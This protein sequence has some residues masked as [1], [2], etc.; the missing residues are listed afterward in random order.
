MQIL[1]IAPTRWLS[2]ANAVNRILQQ[3][4]DL[5]THFQLKRTADKCYTAELLYNMYADIRN[6]L[7]FVFLKPILDDTLSVNKAFQTNNND[8]VKLLNDLIILIQGLA[9]R[10][11]ISGCKE[12]LLKVNVK[13]YLHPHPY[14]G[15]DFEEKM[16]HC[17][18]NN[19]LTVE[20]EMQIRS[21]CI[22]FIIALVSQ[23][24][25]RLP[26]NIEILSNISLLS[27]EKCLRVIKPSVIPLAQ[28]MIETQDT[29]TKIYYQWSKLSYVKWQNV[30]STISF[31]AE[32]EEYRDS[33]NE[34]PFKELVNLALKC[35]V[36][37][38]SNGDVER[39][40]SQMKNVKTSSRNRLHQDTINAILTTRAGL[41]RIE[42]CCFNYEFPS[43]VL[44]QIETLAA[45][46]DHNESLNSISHNTNAFDNKENNDPDD[47]TD[48]SFIE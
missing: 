31:W 13:N 27:P 10:I 40:F 23:L 21:R 33:S 36:L 9:Q 16:K 30:K 15:Y 38:W 39:T 22:D 37:P 26:D 42:K 8:P 2:I 24:Q 19:Y 45:Y 43:S 12:N 20:D 48:T 3:W 17:R 25:Q 1:Q 28:F 14:L 11:V 34:N 35:L 4:L 29:I 5:K 41:R 44:S 7:Y 18:T 46:K 47:N 32:V 6:E